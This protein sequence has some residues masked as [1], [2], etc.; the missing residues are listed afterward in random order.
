MNVQ[1]INEAYFSD[2]PFSF[3]GKYKLV[4]QYGSKNEEIID[5]ALKQNDIYS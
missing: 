1:S 2:N 4:K 5:E 3:G